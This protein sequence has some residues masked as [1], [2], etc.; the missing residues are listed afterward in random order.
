MAEGI[1]ATPGAQRHLTKSMS[2][3]R[4]ETGFDIRTDSCINVVWC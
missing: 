1:R 2:K 3:I 4:L